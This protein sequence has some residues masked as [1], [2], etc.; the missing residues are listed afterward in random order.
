MTRDEFAKA[1]GVDV[2]RLPLKPGYPDVTWQQMYDNSCPDC[3]TFS[4]RGKFPILH[5]DN[6]PQQE[7]GFQEGLKEI[8]ERAK[9]AEN[10]TQDDYEERA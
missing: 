6:C 10:S 1:I 5:Y 4:V 3:K 9:E 8:F 2:N 7:R